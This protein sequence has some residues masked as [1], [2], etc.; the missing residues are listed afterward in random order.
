MKR[1]VCKTNQ[2]WRMERAKSIG[3]SAIGILFGESSF[4]TPMELADK[5]RAELAGEFDFTENMAMRRGH[6]YE[7]GVADLFS[8]FTGKKIIYSS[9]K[10]IICRKEEIPYMH[11]SPDRTYWIDENGQ[12]HGKNAELNKGILECKTTKMHI[13]KDNPPLSWQYQLQ[14][15][16]GIMGMSQGCLAWDELI[17]GGEFGYKFYEFEPD[18]FEAARI[19]CEDFW[20]RCVI[21]GE[22]PDPTASRDILK[23][24]P[25][26]EEG[27]RK[28]V[29]EDIATMIAELK[30]LKDTKK[31]LEADIEE[32]EEKVKMLFDDSEMLVDTQGFP[33]ATYKTTAGRKTIDAKAL[34]KEYPEIYDKYIRQSPS[35]RTL[36]LK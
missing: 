9:S 24:Y 26:S 23:R 7:G 2:Q 32:I 3:A 19:M 1:I 22:D 25:E 29:E 20:Y 8:Y 10:E 21:G 12:K 16:M 18:I 13:D 30:T 5:M 27:K 11:C 34:R 28:E 17:K 6:A 4:V 31:E 36:R 14:V 15:Q 35:T 33:L